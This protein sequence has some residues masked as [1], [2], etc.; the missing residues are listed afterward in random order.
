[1]TAAEEYWEG[2]RAAEREYGEK[3]DALYAACLK[4]LAEEEGEAAGGD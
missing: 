1:M 3:L 4:R 2:I